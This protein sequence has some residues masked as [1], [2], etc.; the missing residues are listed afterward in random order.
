MMGYIAAA[1][2]GFGVAVCLYNWDDW[3]RSWKTKRIIRRYQKL[4]HGTPKRT[5]RLRSLDEAHNYRDYPFLIDGKVVQVPRFFWWH[6]NETH[7]RVEDINGNRLG[8]LTDGLI[9]SRKCDS[10]WYHYRSLNLTES[11]NLNGKS[12]IV[13]AIVEVH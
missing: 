12:V 1:V 5:V 7:R 6:C 13:E 10:G 8:Y 4:L 9:R 2:I 11:A 3:K